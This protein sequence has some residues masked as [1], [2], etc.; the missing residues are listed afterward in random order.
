MAHFWWLC[1]SYVILSQLTIGTLMYVIDFRYKIGNWLW[2]KKIFILV[3]FYDYYE[4]RKKGEIKNSS[5][6]M[7]VWCFYNTN[8]FIFPQPPPNFHPFSQC[9]DKK[10][11]WCCSSIWNK[12]V[13]YYY[14]MCIKPW[15]QLQQR[16]ILFDCL[17][18][19]QLK[20]WF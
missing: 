8:E 9:H 7:K 16:G 20:R 14:R 2:Q 15:Y 10:N 1:H 6:N 17:I 19:L 18:L 5:K 4:R 13:C 3:S 12:N 11:L